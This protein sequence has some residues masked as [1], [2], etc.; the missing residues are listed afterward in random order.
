MDLDH[1][2]V[3]DNQEF[4]HGAL[5]AYGAVTTEIIRREFVHMDKLKIGRLNKEEIVKIVGMG[6][7]NEKDLDAMITKID[8]GNDGIVKHF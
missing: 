1:N 2:E 6:W 5:N 8:V 4:L 3:I 7:I